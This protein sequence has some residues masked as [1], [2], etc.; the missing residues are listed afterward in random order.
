MTSSPTDSIP[1]ATGGVILEGEDLVVEV[2]G[3]RLLDVKRVQVRGGEIL[4][5]LGPN[6]AG[7]S[8][9]LRVLAMLQPAD[10][11]T[12]RFRD[13]SG[14]EADTMLRR[15]CAFVFQR[16]HL[17]AGSVRQNIELG[18]R[19]RRAPPGVRRARASEAA[20]NLGIANLLDRDARSLS[21]GEAQRVAI[22]RAM[23]L[24]PSILCLDEPASNLDA[25]A[26]TALI[27]DLDRVA[28][29]GRH[30]TV[31]ATHDRAD[32]FSIADRV[33]V[34]RNGRIVQSGRPEDLFE[35]PVDPFI[36][37]VTGAELSF[38]ATV[39]SSDEGL[40]RIRVGASDF[41]AVGSAGPGDTVRVVYR[42]EDLFLSRVP[43]EASPRNRFRARVTEIRTAGSL[44]RVRLDGDGH[45]WVAVVTRAAADELSLEV[46][47]EIWVQVK[48]TALHAFHG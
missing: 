25:M 30:A 32:A 4:A 31:I 17:W 2:R 16:P 36:A 11:G 8:T 9:L 48:A 15:E 14:R 46:G 35:N 42:P 40:L 26:R 28:R 19:L 41:S 38:K 21:G 1:P 34:L 24:D 5:V 18:L 23:A 47:K 3:S 6:G 13:K 27:E 10:S 7:K 22:A 45:P 33:V 37:A 39:E 44:E 20:E 43:I 29:D 12:V